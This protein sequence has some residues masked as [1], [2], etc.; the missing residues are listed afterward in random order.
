MWSDA[1][2]LLLNA[3]SRI[4]SDL[5]QV[6]SGSGGGSFQVSTPIV[7]EGD[8]LELRFVQFKVIMRRPSCN[9]I[10]LSGPC[11]DIGGRDDEVSIISELDQYVLSGLSGLRLA[12]VADSVCGWS[13]ARALCDAGR[14]ASRARDVSIEHGMVRV[15]AEKVHQPVVDRRRQ[16]EFS[17]LG[18]ERGVTVSSCMKSNY[19][20]SDHFA[21]DDPLPTMATALITPLLKETVTG[22]SSSEHPHVEITIGVSV[23]A[24]TLYV[25]SRTRVLLLI[26]V[27][28]REVALL[29]LLD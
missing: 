9:V 25:C 12:A 23:S 7:A 15:A 28:C 5:S 16:V 21:G 3:T 13:N 10:D 8:F 18:E 26:A 29:A 14:D 4:L 6:M 11:G 20:T 27:K 24:E 22:S 2:K 19:R 1:D 17:Q